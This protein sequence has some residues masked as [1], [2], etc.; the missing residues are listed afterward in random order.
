MIRL[1]KKYTEVYEIKQLN[2]KVKNILKDRL[3]SNIMK[4]LA[5]YNV[6]LAGGS[7]T[8]ILTNSLIN[9]F[10]LY[11]KNRIDIDKILDKLKKNYKLTCF[12]TNNSYNVEVQIN[13]N[14]ISLQFIT[15][16]EFINKSEL[17]LINSFDF[18]VCML[19][20]NFKQNKLYCDEH[21][22][23]DIQNRTIHY[24]YDNLYP[25]SSLFRINKYKSKGFKI[26]TIEILK[27]TLNIKDLKI[28][29]NRDLLENLK[30]VSTCYFE[31][32]TNY[33]KEKQDIL[34]E[35]Y[36]KHNFIKLLD[37]FQQN[38]EVLKVLEND[39]K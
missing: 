39:K 6:I 1:N 22:Y 10:D 30:G 3:T 21:I 23:E 11:V 15:I 28:E 24:N 20:Y 26:E 2:K 35:K 31:L 37:E 13:N 33:Y 9:D 34:D 5:K 18:S 36:D 27:I 16:K 14:K 32:L 29:S 38:M 4:L 8:S 7:L 19:A 12:V 17:E 25:I